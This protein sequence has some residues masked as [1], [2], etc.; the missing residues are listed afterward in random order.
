[1]ACCKSVATG[2]G[3]HPLEIFAVALGFHLAGSEVA[4]GIQAVRPVEGEILKQ[5]AV[6]IHLDQRAAG[7]LGRTH[8]L[9][10]DADRERLRPAPRSG[11]DR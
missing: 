11:W 5:Y 10:V 8:E 9:H 2:L 7:D 6:Q 1:M 4:A 3:Q